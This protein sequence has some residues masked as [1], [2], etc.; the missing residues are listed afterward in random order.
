MMIHA[1]FPSFFGFGL[2]DGH[3]KLFWVRPYVICCSLGVGVQL[4]PGLTAMK[5]HTH[6]GELFCLSAAVLRR[7][8]A[9]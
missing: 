5:R 3:V 9:P 8:H 2:E 6:E 7:F 4:R 1:A